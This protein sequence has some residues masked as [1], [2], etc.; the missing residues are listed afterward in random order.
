[1]LDKKLKDLEPKKK[2][3]TSVSDAS[4]EMQKICR[5]ICAKIRTEGSRSCQN[6]IDN[7]MNEME[8]DDRLQT[9]E[10]SK[11]SLEIKKAVHY[12]EYIEVINAVKA[13]NNEKTFVFDEKL[14]R[15][16]LD[17]SDK[18]EKDTD[19]EEIEKDNLKK[20]IAATLKQT[21]QLRGMPIVVDAGKKYSDYSKDI[22]DIVKGIELFGSPLYQPIIKATM[23]KIQQDSEL[24][25]R[26]KE[27]LCSRLE[28]H[29]KDENTQEVGGRNR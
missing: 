7:F 27:S 17:Y 28:L 18:I 22:Q 14:Y 6:N 9:T 16:L 12:G 13:M 5:D 8:K 11:L 20:L 25:E 4:K 2:D 15:T 21:N 29:L 1:M 24:S 10:K 23:L 19:L 26:E 3:N